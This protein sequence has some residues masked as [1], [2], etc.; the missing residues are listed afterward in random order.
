MSGFQSKVNNYQAPAVKG[1]FASMNPFSSVLAGP[2][3][4]VAPAGGLIVGNF[5]WVGPEGQT[6]QSYVSGY[7]IAFLGNNLQALIT[8]FLGESTLV[9]PEGFMVTGFNGGDFWTDFPAGAAPG[10]YV[11]ADPNDG[12]A[13]ANTSNSAPTLGTVTATAGFTSASVSVDGTTAVLTVNSV[14]HGIIS[15]GDEITSGT[16]IPANTTILNQLTGTPGGVGTYTMSA[17]STSSESDEAIVIKSSFLY[18]TAVADG[19]LN[20]DDVISGTGVASGTQVLSQKTP[21]SGVASILSGELSQLVV[22]SVTPGTDLLRVGVA[23]PAIP[24]LGIVGGT[25]ISAQ[26]SGTPGGVGTYTLSAAGTVGAGVPVTTED[27]IG[28]TGLYT[29]S[30]GPQAIGTNSAPTTVTV[31]GTAI[32]TGFRVRGTYTAAQ[33]PGAP[34][35]DLWKISATVNG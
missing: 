2:G 33:E 8:Q 19:S 30:N 23:L 35:A 21:F 4:L 34:P 5:F 15:P 20:T 14:T 3:A 29:I 12:Q 31:A 7:Q 16:G 17:D 9:V 32:A 18:V 25:T 6:S 13:V 1:D 24:A 10:D 27:S 11:F 26:V 28:G 22:T